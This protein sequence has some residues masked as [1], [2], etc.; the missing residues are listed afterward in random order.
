VETFANSLK[1]KMAITVADVPALSPD[2]KAA[3]AVTAGVMTS[4]ADNAAFNYLSESPNTNQVWVELVQS[5]RYDWIAANTIVDY[6]DTLSDPRMPLYFDQ[7]LGTGVYDGGVYGTNN[8]YNA[9]THIT[10]AL[11]APDYPCLLMSNTEIQFYLAEAAQRG[12]A[13]GGSAAS[14][15]S[16]GVTS[17]IV[18]DWGGDAADATTYLAQPAVVLSAISDT[19]MDQIALQS[20]LANY[21][22]GMIA[23]TTY[24]RLDAPALNIA[25]DSGLPVPHRYTYP[26]TEQTLNGANYANASSAIGGDTQAS[27]IFWDKQ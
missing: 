23:W 22:R 25:F 13:V 9:Y 20:W 14:F 4:T 19:A 7:N 16:A 8:D 11:Q 12:W 1:L 26:V 21:N 18:D 6:M 15:Y 2:S 5:G 17:S 27:R 3:A 24:R 10:D